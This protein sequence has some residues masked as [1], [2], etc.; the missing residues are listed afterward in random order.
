MT[1][2]CVSRKRLPYVVDVD[3]IPAVEMQASAC[4]YEATLVAGDFITILVQTSSPE[5]SAPFNV[6]VGRNQSYG[7][8]PM[9]Y[10]PE[11]V[12]TGGQAYQYLYPYQIAADGT[13]EL[14]I[15][16]EVNVIG[17]TCR[18]VETRV[19]SMLYP[20]YL[21]EEP[22]VMA[23][24]VSAKV[25][26][27]GD[28]GHGKVIPMEN[29]KLTIFE[30]LG[31]AGDLSLRANRNNVLLIREKPNGEK[32]TYR[33]DL[34]D[35]NLILTPE[36]YYLKQNDVIYVEP[37]WVAGSDANLS[38]YWS[39]GISIVS[40]IMSLATLVVTLATSGS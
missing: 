9:D 15:L 13:I 7:S 5:A 37:N 25:V 8:M 2:S 11:S 10:G 35:K 4:L 30:A 31:Q 34:Q 36:L 38:R 1:I 32:M 23:R 17:A 22:L 19:K 39:F 24:M 12:A 27:L 28:E 14:P 33:I 21:K 26:L 29:G 40:T 20:K 6:A 3:K 16:G 18:E